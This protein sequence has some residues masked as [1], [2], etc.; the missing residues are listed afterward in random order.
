MEFDRAASRLVVATVMILSATA[1]ATATAADVVISSSA[2]TTPTSSAAAL[3]SSIPV[4]GVVWHED[5]NAGWAEARRLGRP[6]VIFITSKHCRYCDAMKT[7]TWRDG[8]VLH[9][10]KGQFVA[11]RLSPDR[12]ASVLRRI[13]IPAYPMTLIGSPRGKVVDHRVGYQPPSALLRLLDVAAA[14]H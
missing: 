1:A 2:V 9:R 5:L 3:P 7:G 13:R 10:M 4:D 14:S 6:M 8:T 11:I 12:N